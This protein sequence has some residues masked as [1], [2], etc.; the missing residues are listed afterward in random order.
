MIFVVVL[1]HYYQEKS[2]KKEKR[3]LK[4]HAI[5]LL[6]PYSAR[7]YLSSLINRC[8]TEPGCVRIKKKKYCT[9][10]SRFT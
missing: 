1:K 3:K 9:R 5:I 8:V 4:F 2:K 10:V 6:T 7:G